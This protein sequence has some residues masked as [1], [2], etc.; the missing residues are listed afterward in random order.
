MI[1]RMFIALTALVALASLVAGSM[2]VEAATCTVLSAKARSWGQATAMERVTT[3]LNHKVNRWA[4]K[5]DVAAVRVGA[6][7]TSCTPKGV[8]FNCTRSLRVCG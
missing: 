5:N 6:P 4:N 3:K 7:S 8:L 1:R 2:P